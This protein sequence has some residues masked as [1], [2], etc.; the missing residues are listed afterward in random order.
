MDFLIYQ[1]GSFLVHPSTWLVLLMWTVK[2]IRVYTVY[3]ILTDWS[4]FTRERFDQIQKIRNLIKIKKIWTIVWT[5]Y[6][7]IVWQANLEKKASESYTFINFRWRKL[8]QMK[9]MICLLLLRDTELH[10]AHWTKLIPV[11]L[12][13]N[14]VGLNT[15]VNCLYTWSSHQYLIG[16][17]ASPLRR[18]RYAVL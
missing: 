18:P 16:F 3:F 17:L 15:L 8:H 10:V 4:I 11:T 7:F 6:C 2:G 1:F 9:M 14:G 12:G 5:S 13:T